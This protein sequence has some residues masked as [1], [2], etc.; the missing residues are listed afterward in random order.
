MKL[1]TTKQW[2]TWW[3]A[4]KIDWVASYQNWNHPH[5]FL[6]SALL[7]RFPWISLFEVGVGGG[8]NLINILQ[9]FKNKQLGGCDVNPEAIATVSKTLTGGLFKV[10]SVED[11]M[12]SDSSTDII[13]SDMCLIYLGHRRIHQAIKEIR[14]VARNRIVLCEFHSSSL[15]KRLKLRYTSGYNAYDYRQLLKRHDFYDIELYKISEQAWPGGEPQK[16]YGYLITA[17]V[18]K[19][20]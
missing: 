4:R 14:R 19:R 12:L 3:C 16:S 11:I 13:L 2:R 1:R 9:H 18:P 17:K 15:Y 7:S 5:R 10:S 20:K 8:A 6:I